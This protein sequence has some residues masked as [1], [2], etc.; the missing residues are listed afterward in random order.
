MGLRFALQAKPLKCSFCSGLTVNKRVAIV[1]CVVLT[2][3]AVAVIGRGHRRRA[4]N[5]VL[6]P[7]LDFVRVD[8]LIQRTNPIPRP[9]ERLKYDIAYAEAFS[10][11]A[12]QGK[13][14]TWSASAD[15][16]LT[17]V[18]HQYCDFAGQPVYVQ[19]SLRKTKL[20][21]LHFAALTTRGLIS[22]FERAM[23]TNQ[24]VF[25]RDKTNGVWIMH[26]TNEPAFRGSLAS[27]R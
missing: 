13:K 22:D 7:P 17:A 9:V 20:G 18:L 16:P 15:V 23:K 12:I 1:A 21:A 25:V 24:L 8:S 6:E 10:S 14:I 27:A 26:T 19:T 5:A 3:V 11:G 4:P 2:V